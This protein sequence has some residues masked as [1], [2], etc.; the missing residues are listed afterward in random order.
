MLRNRK[1][2]SVHCKNRYLLG[3]PQV[4][5]QKHSAKRITTLFSVPMPSAATARRLRSESSGSNRTRDFSDR[6]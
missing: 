2:W 5:D 4:E 1:R 6:P 3:F